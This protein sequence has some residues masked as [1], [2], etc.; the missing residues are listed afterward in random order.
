MVRTSRLALS[1]GFVACAFGATWGL[2][3]CVQASQTYLLEPRASQIPAVSGSVQVER[4]EG[5]QRLL[6][7]SLRDL[8]PPEELGLHEFAVWVRDADG[9]TVKLGSL[10]Y[11][12]TQ[13]SGSLLGLVDSA[14]AFRFTVQVTGERDENASAPSELLLAERTVINH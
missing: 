2:S 8:P 13:G 3:A 7:I 9:R 12:R 10:R 5:G 6:A 11:D 1:L 4:I 14:R